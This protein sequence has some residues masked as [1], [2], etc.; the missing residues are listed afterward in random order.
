[1][2]INHNFERLRVQSGELFRANV[3]E[4]RTTYQFSNRTFVRVITQYFDVRRNPAL[5]T[6]AVTPADHTLLNQFLF[7][8]KINPQVVLFL[9]YSDN[10]QNSPLHDL[11]Q[12]NRTVFFKVG[13]AFVL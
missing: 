11:T 10:Y 5:Y 4:V 2:K 12:V 13:Y 1:M 8:Y 7:S 9:G 3:S 6:F